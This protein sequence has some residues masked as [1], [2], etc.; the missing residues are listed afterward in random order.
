MGLPVLAIYFIKGISISSK[1][2]TLYAGVSSDSSKSTADSSNGDEKIS[3]P[4]SLE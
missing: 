2:A 4:I 1:D 3:I